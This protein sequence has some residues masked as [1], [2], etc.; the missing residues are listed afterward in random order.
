MKVKIKQKPHR[1][2]FK[3]IKTELK[4]YPVRRFEYAM[5]NN[6]V[7]AIVSNIQY[8]KDDKVMKFTWNRINPNGTVEVEPEKSY[9]FVHTDNI[10]NLEIDFIGYAEI[11]KY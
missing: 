11:V 7:T 1:V 3:N 8:E 4:K 9:T 6:V 10:D 5:Y 2:A